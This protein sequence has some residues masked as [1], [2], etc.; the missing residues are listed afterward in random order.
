[1]KI[2]IALLDR[3]TWLAPALALACILLAGF[4]DMHP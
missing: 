2:I 3:H 4:M 1:M